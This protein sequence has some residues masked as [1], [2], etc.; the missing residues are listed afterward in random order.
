MQLTRSRGTNAACSTCDKHYFFL[1]IVS[2]FVLLL[3]Y[4]ISIAAQTRGDGCGAIGSADHAKP[5]G[6]RGHRLPFISPKRARPNRSSR[7]PTRD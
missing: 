5:I 6:C 3:C 4:W 7:L 1:K 2:H